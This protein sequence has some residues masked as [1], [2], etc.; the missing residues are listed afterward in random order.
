MWYR[1]IQVIQK[2]FLFKK[3]GINE[4]FVHGSSLIASTSPYVYSANVPHLCNTAV[5]FHD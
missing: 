4:I 1:K 2:N 3:L 5:M